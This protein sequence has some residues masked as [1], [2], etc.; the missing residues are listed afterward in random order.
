MTRAIVLATAVDAEYRSTAALRLS[1]DAEV[2]V[3]ERL[4]GQLVALGADDVELVV[5]RKHVDVFAG[6]SGHLIDAEDLAAA[7]REVARLARETAEPLI[8]AAGDVVAHDEALAGLVAAPGDATGALV[9]MIGA[10]DSD[11]TNSARPPARVEH[12]R[13][14]SAAS[15]YH[16]VTLPNARSLG[17]LRV[18]DA[19]RP[20]LADVADELAGL[21][22]EYAGD[23]ESRIGDPVSLLLVGLVRDGV[24]VA[25]RD[26]RTLTARRVTSE[27]ALRETERKIAGTDEDRVRLESAVKGDD[28]FFTTYAVSTYSR[29]IARWAAR[30]DMSPNTITFINMGVAVLASLCFASGMRAGMI[31]GAVLLY[32]A[33]VLDCVDG[34]LAR[35]ARKFSTL[36]AW[37]DATGDRAKEYVAY[38][39]LAV[40]STMGGLGNVWGLATAAML[41]QTVRHMIDF[42]YAGAVTT[43]VAEMPRRAL[44]EHGDGLGDHVTGPAAA[45]QGGAY[46]RKRTGA[47][48]AA[49]RTV[50]RLSRGFDSR[51]PLRWFKK[52]VV[53]PIGERFALICVLA[54]VTT[55]R[56]T[57]IAVLAW[58]GLAACYTLAGRVFRSLAR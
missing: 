31:V 57:L 17:V 14:V 2:P 58:G 40:G 51:G 10:A 42:S 7:L 15:L 29:Y 53:L 30:R 46:A 55:P 1:G 35:Y 45:A 36:G 11:A 26:V 24:K 44:R 20:R 12:G 3:Y 41:L 8:L 6:A 28:G 18:R 49:G 52:I 21:A 13:I 39:G 34:Q 27:D 9:E 38:A 43:E 47:A 32:F 48:A 22:A 19:D 16:W 4:R 23:A 33:F 56:T 5:R 25:A 37:L 50:V 54:A